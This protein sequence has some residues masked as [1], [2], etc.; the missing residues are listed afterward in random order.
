VAIGDEASIAAHL[1]ASP[2][3]LVNT[4]HVERGNPDWRLWDAH[5]AGKSPTLAKAH[6]RLEARLAIRVAWYNFARP[7]DSLG[8]RS[9]IAAKRIT[10]AMAAGIAERQ[11]RIDDVVGS[12]IFVN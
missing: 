1:A 12:P 10:P 3:E 9:S 11:W 7:H 2:S 8:T 6:R 5:L 4:A